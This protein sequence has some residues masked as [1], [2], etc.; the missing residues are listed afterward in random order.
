[1]NKEWW[2]CVIHILV[3]KY[4][5]EQLAKYEI[6]QNLSV[7]PE[8]ALERISA[9]MCRLSDGKKRE[10]GL[11][12]KSISRNFYRKEKIRDSRIFKYN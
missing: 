12:M 7:R 5:C 3:G 2:I 10:K 6:Q 4:S 11:E 1:M 9:L 8:M